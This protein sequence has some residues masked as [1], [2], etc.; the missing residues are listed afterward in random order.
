LKS[1]KLREKNNEGGARDRLGA[2][3]RVVTRRLHAARL[4][5]VDGGLRHG[6]GLGV[7]R[8][9]QLMILARAG[10]ANRVDCRDD[11]ST[12]RLIDANQT[13]TR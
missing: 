7:H 12:V 5:R 11:A 9:V 4:N 6:I 8:F 3:G 1:K 10:A 2:G 13:T